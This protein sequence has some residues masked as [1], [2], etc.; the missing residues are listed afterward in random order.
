MLQQNNSR[1][2][3]EITT[4]QNSSVTLMQAPTSKRKVYPAE[5]KYTPKFFRR[6]EGEGAC[7]DGGKVP[8]V[9]SGSQVFAPFLWSMQ[10]M[11]Q[12]LHK[13]AQANSTH[14]PVSSVAVKRF[15]DSSTKTSVPL[16]TK[17]QR[18]RPMTSS[19][20][21]L[22]PTIARLR[23]SALLREIIRNWASFANARA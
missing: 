18:N 6:V 10:T 2:I 19:I 5:H 17:L 20:A 23:C 22:S 16:T 13:P 7:L 1:N 11:L 14:S 21:N 4:G 12:R 15:H 9:R 3:G 8:K